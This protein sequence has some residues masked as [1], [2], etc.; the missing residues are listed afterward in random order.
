MPLLNPFRTGILRKLDNKKKTT[1]N[2][3]LKGF[4]SKAMANSESK[5]TFS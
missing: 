4:I 2:A 5:P 1:K 3:T